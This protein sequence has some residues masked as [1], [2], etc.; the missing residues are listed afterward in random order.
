M[1]AGRIFFTNTIATFEDGPGR[2]KARKMMTYRPKGF[3]FTRAFK[4]RYWDGYRCLM[5]PGGEFPAGLMPWIQAELAKQHIEVTT[6]DRRP[7]PPLRVAGL[8]E[9]VPVDLRPYQREA[10]EAGKACGRGILMYPT[11]S[12]KTLVMVE[13]GREIGVNG[14]ILVHKKDLLYQTY[15][16]LEG[17]VGVA[18]AG[19]IGDGVWNPVNTG[20]TVATFQTL[21][22]RLDDENVKHWLKTMIGQV[23]VDEAQHLEAKT[24]GA[25]MRTLEHCAYWFG[26]SAT[27]F[28]GGSPEEK[29][30]VMSWAGPVIATITR[31]ELV[32]DGYLVDADV[33]M[34]SCD[35]HPKREARRTYLEDQE[36]GIVN[37]QE[38]NQDIINIAK[39]I[40]D[41]GAGPTLI[42]VDRLEHGVKLAFGL[43]CEFLAGS[44][45]S[46]R[47]N[48]M[49]QDF[50]D[51]KVPVLVA[52]RIADEGVNIPN[53]QYLI[54]A[55]GGKAPHLLVQ[56]VGRGSRPSEGKERL[57]VFDFNDPVVTEKKEYH[58]RNGKKRTRQ[59]GGYVGRHAKSR[60][61][62]YAEAE[63]SV[64][65]V[66]V[67][68]IINA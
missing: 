41:R 44:D 57:F 56:R 62:A 21:H 55:G 51:G 27:P 2:E 4:S 12:G 3:Q 53:L 46:G 22:E 28:K 33:F 7:P 10:V 5:S 34:V 66:G 9:R 1:T 26:H 49:W 6:E 52:S 29:L 31:M 65:H 47:R 43:G 48:K 19:M 15:D 58:D 40:R 50:R 67:E 14:L 54:L 20:L 39:W 36:Y 24:F 61:E 25:V 37:N 35:S 45:K 60:L 17:I 13:L 30:A 42:L 38:R 63:F 16:V 32:D 64:T 68:E 23:H 8:T 18:H 11:G 59:I